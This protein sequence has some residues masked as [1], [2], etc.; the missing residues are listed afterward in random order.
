MKVMMNRLITEDQKS[1]LKTKF[2]DTEFV[3]TNPSDEVSNLA[4]IG[5]DCEVIVGGDSKELI[6]AIL[7][8]PNKLRWVQSW[9]AGVNHIPLQLLNEHNVL[10]TRAGGVSVNPISE[11]VIGLMIMLIRNM[12]QMGKQQIA[13]QWVPM[14]WPDEIHG[15]TVGILGLG[16]IGNGLAKLCKA[17]NMEV[18]GFQ[19]KVKP[20]KYANHIVDNSHLADLL[21][22]SDFVVNILP[23]TKETT[24]LMDET[25][26]KQMKSDA[27]YINVGR[28][29]T[30]D[31]DAMIKA[32][33]EGWIKGAGL[34]V[35][36]IEPLPADN[37][38]WD[39]DNVIILPHQAGLTS[40]YH[41]RVL[42]IFS[43][44]FERFLAGD[45]LDE[46]QADLDRGY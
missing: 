9:F 2:P 45:P 4:K 40:K 36:S 43:R 10:L 32:L 30:T 23:L 12:R 42:E 35:V 39:M 3:W 22:V 27:Y 19:G 15:K 11:T 18:W 46:N 34:D 38:L 41:D 1:Q 5:S 33:Q 21:A 6:E 29:A 26:F 37:P 31:T 14:D 24:N 13:H 17:F 7:S 20:S 25:R 44:N 16:V 28:G 8:G